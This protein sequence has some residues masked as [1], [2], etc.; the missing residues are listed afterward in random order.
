METVQDGKVEVSSE[1]AVKQNQKAT[2]EK[3]AVGILLYLCVVPLVAPIYGYLNGDI[4][5]IYS[6]WH[7]SNLVVGAFGWLLAVVAGYWWYHEQKNG[8]N[9]KSFMKSH[10]FCVAWLCFLIWSIFSFLGSD[11]RELSFYGGFFQKDGLRAYFGYAGVLLAAMCIRNRKRIRIVMEG[12]VGASTLVALIPAINNTSLYRKINANVDCSTFLNSNHYGYYVCITLLCGITLFVSENQKKGESKSRLWS[13]LHLV[14]IIVISNALN[15][16]QTLGAFFGVIGGLILFYIFIGNVDK[17]RRIR[18]LI[19]TGIF[20]VIFLFLHTGTWD[21]IND[22]RILFS[23]MGAIASN[24]A[25]AA[26]AGTGRWKLW[27]G[28]VKLIAKKPVFGYGPQNLG[29]AY[30]QLGLADIVYPHNEILQFGAMLGIPAIMFYL[31][32]M[33]SLVKECLCKLRK[34]DVEVLGIFCSVGAYVVS[35]MFGVTFFYTTPFYFLMLG[36]A[37]S[38]IR[39]VGKSKKEV[40]TVQEEKTK[41]EPNME[42]DKNE[43]E[44]EEKEEEKE[45]EEKPNTKNDDNKEVKANS[46]ENAKVEQ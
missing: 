30:A 10:V 32:A 38:S 22:F 45:K 44:N 15:L 39:E 40:D 11:N 14:E 2:L 24:E 35:S 25:E 9:A 29:N 13:L 43:K 8:M 4:L 26:E 28:A 42:Q 1:I 23:D 34:I 21:I 17:S 20:F 19:A 6:F 33:F 37:Y 36:L 5:S 27:V 7:N 31:T 3:F 16:C 41:E 46:E 12:F 18:L